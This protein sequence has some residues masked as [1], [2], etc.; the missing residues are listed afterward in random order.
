MTKNSSRLVQN[1]YFRSYSLKRLKSKAAS[2]VG[3]NESWEENESFAQLCSWG[4]VPRKPFEPH[5]YRRS[6]PFTR[7]MAV[8]SGGSAN[9]TVRAA[10]RLSAVEAE[11]PFARPKAVRSFGAFLNSTTESYIGG[12]PG[13]KPQIKTGNVGEQS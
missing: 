9:P 12:D 11:R 7:P 3:R 4:Q 1:C 5:S 13:E 8:E 10:I 2:G 6:F